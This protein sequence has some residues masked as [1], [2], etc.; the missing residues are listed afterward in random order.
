MCLRC[1]FLTYGKHIFYIYL[2]IVGQR[3]KGACAGCTPTWIFTCLVLYLHINHQSG[4][5]G[6]Q[7]HL[8]LCRIFTRDWFCRWCMENNVIWGNLATFERVANRRSTSYAYQAFSIY[9]R[10]QQKVQKFKPASSN[11]SKAAW[12]RTGRRW[13]IISE[14]FRAARKWSTFSASLVSSNRRFC[15]WAGI[16]FDWLQTSIHMLPGSCN[17]SKREWIKDGVQMCM[18]SIPYTSNLKKDGH[19][20]RLSPFSCSMM[21]TF[22]LA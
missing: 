5:A 21:S 6:L 8:T 4:I 14:G 19:L 12:S 11:L 2:L 13:V 16:G 22:S 17:Q 20:P 15:L 7:D 10:L 9:H 3:K 18:S 1:D